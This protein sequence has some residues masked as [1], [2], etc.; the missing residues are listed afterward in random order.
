MKKR[1]SIAC[2]MAIGLICLS[3]KIAAEEIDAKEKAIQALKSEDYMT[4]IDICRNELA[5]DPNNYDFGFILSRAYAYSRQWDQALEVLTQMLARYPDNGDLI[6]Q[7]SR[8]LGWK[9]HYDEADAGFRA[10]L[11]KDPENKEA[12][13]GRAEI[14]SWKNDFGDA[15]EK[16]RQ[17]LR[18]EPDD[19]DIHFRIGRIYLWEGNYSEARRYFGNACELAPDNIEYG[20]ALK[21]ARPELKNDYELRVQ[22]QNEAFSD[23]RGSYTGQQ[24][25]FSIKISPRFGSLHLKYDRTRRFGEPDAQFGIELYPHLWRKAYGYIDF[26]LSP[27]AIHYPRTS[28]VLE[29]Y[30]SLLRASEISLGYRR[31]NFASQSVSIYLGSLGYYLGSF[32]PFFRWYYTPEDNGHNFSWTVNV[33]KYFT[34]DSYLSLGYGQGSRPFDIITI[35]DMLVLESR[36]FLA[37][38]NWFLWKRIR[39]QVQFAHRNEKDGPTRNAVFVST[40]YRW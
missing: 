27:D 40:G 16:Y 10:V 31:M 38:W 8:I 24:A 30:Q 14:A 9:G 29:I 37:E 39:L 22:Y 36:I 34:K 23:G 26:S 28:Y 4:A 18:L 15:R 35:E 12:L 17:A 20:R 11:D 32:Y 6:L 19:P 7:Q 5:S 33:R 25:V 13:I 3:A 2:W 1:K 21:D